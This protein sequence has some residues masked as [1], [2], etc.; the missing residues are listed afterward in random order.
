[1]RSITLRQPRAR[2]VCRPKTD[3]RGR[4][5]VQDSYASAAA[6]ARSSFG[7]WLVAV[8]QRERRFDETSS[9]AA[10]R[11]C[12]WRGNQAGTSASQACGSISLSL[13]VAMR[14]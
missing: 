11:E 10:V 9:K 14:V 6:P 8:K 2:S 7:G 12:A 4:I 13:A 5:V 3:E 1:M